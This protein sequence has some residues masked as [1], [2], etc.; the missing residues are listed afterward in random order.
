MTKRPAIFL[1]RDGTIIEDRGYVSRPEEVTLLPGAADAI[2]RFRRAGFRVVVVSNQSGVA[3]GLFTEKDLAAVH[4]RLEE[5]LA[6]EG[7]ALDAAYYCPF[8]DGPDAVIEAY[9]R[10]SDLRKPKPGMLLQ[11]ARD[12]HLDLSRSWMIGDAESDVEAGRRAGCRTIWIDSKTAPGDKNGPDGPQRVSNLREA[13]DIVERAMQRGDDGTTVEIDQ[14]QR[15]ENEDVARSL[16]RLQ[17]H[18]ERMEKHVEQLARDERQDDF[19]MVR[20]LAALL[21]MF[22]VAVGLWG[23][24]AL[25]DRQ[26][27]A[28]TGRFTL[29]CFLQIGALTAFVVDRFR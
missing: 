29:A 16:R 6:K 24:L 28:A 20:L 3:R 27:A 19:S 17:A 18:V 4:Q 13:A 14:T 26:D 22:A 9:R 25:F 8:L 12:L 2:S 5:T 21:Q 1:D 11:A 15:V 7:A 23:L 10:E